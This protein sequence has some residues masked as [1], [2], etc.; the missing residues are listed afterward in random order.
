MCESSLEGDHYNPCLKSD[1][2]EG[3]EE[4]DA[5]IPAPC[6]D[7]VTFNTLVLLGIQVP[8]MLWKRLEKRQRMVN[9]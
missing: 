6:S 9:V 3:E 4:S 7:T 2:S 1:S 5:Q 8:K